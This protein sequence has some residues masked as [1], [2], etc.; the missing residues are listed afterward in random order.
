M[1]LAVLSL[2]IL[3]FFNVPS[4]ALRHHS[5]SPYITQD[6]VDS[7]NEKAVTWEA[8]LNTGSAIAGATIEEIKGMLGVIPG[9]PTLPVKTVFELSPVQVPDSF[10]SIDYWPH[11]STM[12]DIRDQ[13]ACGSC[14]AFA[15]VEAISDRMCI[16]LNKNIS[17]SSAALTFC[18]DGCGFGCG[19][20][21]PEAAW[22][23]WNDN[24][25]V[26][27]GCW[28]YPF[29]SCDHHVPNSKNP[30][31]SSEYSNKPCANKCNTEWVGPQWTSDLHKGKTA[32]SA[33]GEQNIMA[34]IA[35]NGPVETA[36][37]V[38]ADF[39]TYK[40]GVYHH[41]TG[42]ALGGHAVKI[43][44]WGVENNQKY[45][46]VANSWNPTWGDEGYFKILKGTN[47]CGI[48]GSISAGLPSS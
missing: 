9:G 43:L 34:E 28:P 25:L 3:F 20:G 35:A 46:L 13:S 21:F 47:E 24:G 12:R 17:L 32:Y 42:D 7:V 36:F 26:E 6:F 19:G 14:W 31:P 33:K 27:E 40:S 30:C 29:A 41:T 48:E 23:Y 10:N 44:G 5:G 4:D 11:C 18:C 37:T 8:H 22:Q 38:Y 16:F 2:L 45:W 39:L 15:A 1:K